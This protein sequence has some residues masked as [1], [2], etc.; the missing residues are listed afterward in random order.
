MPTSRKAGAPSALADEVDRRILAA[1]AEDGRLSVNELARLAEVSRATA[2][3]R[4]ERLQASGAI[5]GFHAD[6]DPLALGE[7]ITAMVLVNVEQGSW[8][9][10]REELVRLPGFEYLAVTSGGFD[11]VVIVRVTDVGALR[12]VVLH[13]LH[14]IDAV[15]STQTVF[16]LDE[17]R[18]PVGTG[19]AHATAGA[20]R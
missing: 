5:R 19:A 3:A 2:Y 14:R 17:Q 9:A 13:R 1:L 15:R 11:F 16:V 20:G 4:L 10:V 8:Q 18:R 7:S 6:V 12:D